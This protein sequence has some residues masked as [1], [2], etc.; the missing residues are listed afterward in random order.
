MKYWV[1]ALVSGG[2]I[3]AAVISG[4]FYGVEWAANVALFVLWFIAVI[5]IFY[6]SEDVQRSL[7]TITPSLRYFH[8]A[9]DVS[10]VVLLAAGGWFVTA[11]AVATGNVLKHGAY[12][13]R[14]KETAGEVKA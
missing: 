8:A 3:F 2:A 14:E 6:V 10:L 5:S 13:K 9:L 1:R 7:P 11:A 4:M 12:M